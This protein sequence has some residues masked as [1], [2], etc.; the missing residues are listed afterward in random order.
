VHNIR[1]KVAHDMHADQLQIILTKEQLKKAIQV[2]DD[3]ATRILPIVRPSHDVSDALLFERLL[4]LADHA[5]LGNGVDAVGQERGNRASGEAKR[6]AHRPAG[7]LHAGRG[8]GGK[9]DEVTRGINIF[10]VRLEMLVHG[11]DPALGFFHPR[12][13]ESQLGRIALSSRR[14]QHRIRGQCHTG[15]EF[16]PNATGFQRNAFLHIFFPVK[17]DSAALK[18]THQCLGNFRIQKRKEDIASVEDVDLGA[19]RAEGAP[20]FSADHTGPDEFNAEKFIELHQ[21]ER[22]S[23]EP[24]A[25]IQGWDPQ[26]YAEAAGDIVK[27]GF[28]YIALGGL[29]RS[30]SE[31]IVK[32]LTEV[33]EVVRGKAKIHLFGITRLDQYEVF[34]GLDVL[35]FDGAGPLRRAWLGD[36]DNYRTLTRDPITQDYL[37]YRAIRVPEI[38]ERWELGAT[39]Q[40][41]EQRA[42][43]FLRQFDQGGTTVEEILQAI[44]QYDALLDLKDNEKQLNEEHYRRTL[45]AAPWRRCPCQI[46]NKIGIE[47]I[48]YR[49]KNRNRRRG[50]HNTYVFYQ[51]MK[52]GPERV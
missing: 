42:L 50:F 30:T 51:R 8:K 7:L 12:L 41:A 35:S 33:S 14:D 37:D 32:V 16:E 52:S 36:T 17:N 43:E 20:V 13:L 10:D 48:I 21:S 49:G 29:V 31:Q 19:K 24:I 39:G 5:D 4:R 6:V 3:P 15:G 11:N 27:M 45:E 38:K 34:A 1:R 22:L 18:R 40:R 46:C 47:V 9:T 2:A 25:S 26:S 23:W 44:N 28:R